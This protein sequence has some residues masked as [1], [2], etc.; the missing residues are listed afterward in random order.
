[1]TGKVII[2]ASFIFVIIL[3]TA[4][5]FAAEPIPPCGFFGDVSVNGEPAPVGTVVIAYVNGMNSGSLVTINAGEYGRTGYH[6][7][8]L[9]SR[10]GTEG[11]TVT[12]YVQS[13]EMSS[14]AQADETSTWEAGIVK[15]INLTATYTTT[16]GTDGG[17]NPPSG[18]SGGSGGSGDSGTDSGSETESNVTVDVGLPEPETLLIDL[19]SGENETAEMTKAQPGNIKL[20]GNLYS[21]RVKSMSD[22][23]VLLTFGEDNDVIINLQDSKDVDLTGD[24]VTDIEITLDD[25]KDNVAQMTFARL[26]KNPLGAGTEGISGFLIANPLMGSIMIM[27]LIVL[28]GGTY[29]IHRRRSSK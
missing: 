8:Y 23:G 6:D 16:S 20:N 25:V 2:G 14:P 17:E 27:V 22:F 29:Y 26:E 12:F 18:G 3:L 21:F 1:M 11:A 5:A 19:D 7:G 24:Y 28:F 13:P 10:D 4:G 15:E 9:L